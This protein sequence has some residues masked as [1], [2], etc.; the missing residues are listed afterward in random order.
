ME[1]GGVV[2]L[3]ASHEVIATIADGKGLRRGA[4]C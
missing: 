1:P 4:R 2:Q 3:L